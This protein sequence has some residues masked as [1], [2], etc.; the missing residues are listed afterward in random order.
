MVSSRA[1]EYIQRFSKGV[2][3]QSALERIV[4]YRE[5]CKKMYHDPKSAG[6]KFNNY[7]AQKQWQEDMIERIQALGEA[8]D[9]LQA[10][11]STK[12]MYSAMPMEKYV[13]KNAPKKDTKT[14]EYFFARKAS[15]F[16]GNEHQAKYILRFQG[17]GIDGSKYGCAIHCERA[18]D[19]YQDELIA[20]CNRGNIDAEFCNVRVKALNYVRKYFDKIQKEIKKLDPSS[21]KDYEYVSSSDPEADAWYNDRQFDS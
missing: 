12:T 2:D 11:L 4:E 13:E 21:G 19:A 5:E 6:M 9:S 3:K 16:E 8:R 1:A 18:A 14:P 15:Q 20:S 17:L 7:P 10:S